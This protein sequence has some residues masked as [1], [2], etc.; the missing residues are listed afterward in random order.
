[1]TFWRTYYHLVWSTK[2]RD[3]L[4]SSK[5]EA[6]LNAYLIKQAAGQEAYVYAI[7]GCTDHIHIICAIPPKLAVADFV[8]QLK[9]SS[10]HD[11]N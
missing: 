1:M 5:I 6:R 2:N 10:S 4:I 8:K 11:L 9:G 7:G 3:H